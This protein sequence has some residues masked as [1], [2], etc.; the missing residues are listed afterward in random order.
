MY[1]NNDYRVII[2]IIKYD[3]IR[4]YWLPICF[5]HYCMYSWSDNGVYDDISD[6]NILL[7]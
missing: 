7:W 4:V 2:Q 6:I 1:L 5:I 3:L